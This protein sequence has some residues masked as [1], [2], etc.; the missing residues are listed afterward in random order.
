MTN[1]GTNPPPRLVAHVHGPQLIG[2]EG[3]SREPRRCL[4]DQVRAGL[5]DLAAGAGRPPASSRAVDKNREFLGARPKYSEVETAVTV[6]L[7]SASC[8]TVVL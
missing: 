8:R 5:A 3:Q 6:A 2:S 1:P 4:D 7:A